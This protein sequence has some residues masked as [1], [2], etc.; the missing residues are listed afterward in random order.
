MKLTELGGRLLKIG[1]S[2]GDERQFFRHDHPYVSTADGVMFLCPKC[3]V[4]K[5]DSVGIHSV[6]CWACHVPQEW[7]PKPG[8]WK[9]DGNSLDTLTLNTC[10]GK[11]RSVLLL[12]GC[13]WHG[14]IT[15]GEVTTA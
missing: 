8:R 3:F 7:G 10:P 6:I 12:G 11:S 13:K 2:A 1:S 4:A 14:Y 5:G 9:L 15:D